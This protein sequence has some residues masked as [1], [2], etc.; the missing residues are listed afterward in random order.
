M[1]P[2]LATPNATDVVQSCSN[3]SATGLICNKPVDPQQHHCVDTEEVS[4]AGMHQWP[5]V[6]RTSNTHTVAP[7]CSLNNKYLLSFAL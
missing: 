5:D 7:R 4:I 6:Q 1:L 3:K 2:H